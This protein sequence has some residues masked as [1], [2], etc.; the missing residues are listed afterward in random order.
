LSQNVF[1]PKDFNESKEL[2]FCTKK[3][4][5]NGWR[6]EFLEFLTEAWEMQPKYIS[7]N[8]PR[9]CNF[10]AVAKE[11]KESKLLYC[12]GREIAFYLNGN[13]SYEEDDFSK[14]ITNKINGA[15]TTIQSF[16]IQGLFLFLFFKSSYLFY[17]Y[18]E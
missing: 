4:I 10:N 13:Q 11:F 18:C 3:N 8:G 14:T 15:Q 1:S 7:K 9:Y 17:S 12:F 2:M 6:K 5:N 16:T